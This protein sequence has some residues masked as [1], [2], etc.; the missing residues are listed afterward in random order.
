MTTR[1]TFEDRLLTELRSEIELRAADRTASAEAPAARRRV[2]TRPRLALAAAA[3]S[4]AG[5]AVVLVP[6]SP[7][8]TPAYAV[9]RHGDGSV[10]LTMKDMSLAP[11]AQLQ[12][13][14]RLRA[15]GIHVTIDDLPAGKQCEQP[16]GEPLPSFWDGDSAE[17]PHRVEDEQRAL[18]REAV[19]AGTW[20]TT[21]HPGDSLAIENTRPSQADRSE[22]LIVGVYAVRGE[23]GAC[24]P[25]E[26]PR[27]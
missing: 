8:D 27:H 16:R 21:L 7:A 26:V 6:G 15:Q 20:K 23:V 13:A 19:R 14:E 12:L 4:A 2:L 11:D 25:V 17:K 5:L 24:K 18:V 3:C 10:T 1:T 22:V 9:Q